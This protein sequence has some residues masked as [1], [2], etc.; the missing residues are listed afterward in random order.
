MHKKTRPY[1][2][3]VVVAGLLLVWVASGCAT[4]SGGMRK[5]E[6][7]LAAND[8]AGALKELED[9]KPA[10]RDQVLYR[11][12]RGIIQ[13]M[14]G[15][16]KA[17]SESFEST[18]A[19]S[20]KL[21]AVSVSEQAGAVTV[22]DSMRAYVGEPHERLLMQVYTMLNYMESG[23]F[24]GAR[25][26][27]LQTDTLQQRLFSGETEEPFS[28]YLTGIVYESLG[29]Y[30]DALIAYRKSYQSY[31]QGFKKQP[32]PIPF[33]LKED[34]L[35]FTDFRGMTDESKEFQEQFKINDWVK[36][37]ATRDKGE[38]ILVYNY[39]LAP[40]MMEH[41]TFIKVA[42]RGGN[43]RISLPYYPDRGNLSMPRARMVVGDQVRAIDVVADVD[44][45]A[46]RMLDEKLPGVLARTTARAIV[47]TKV[48]NEIQKQNGALG[49]L[50]NVAGMVSEVADT[51]SWS[52][53]PS[54]I[55]VT[56]M[57]LAPGTYD[58]HVQLVDAGGAQL[59]EKILTGVEIK[60]GKKKVQSVHWVTA[61][62][63]Y[64][65]RH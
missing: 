22:N 13:R 7:R 33:S 25:V 41:S 58:I 36:M 59:P 51:R 18:K 35:R 21:D 31:K 64:A 57:Y 55:G 37:D 14:K 8:Y 61:R 9:Q 6:S 60:K 38:L 43:I 15:D 48:S 16:L 53:L 1:R 46:R 5:V 56:R 17:S 11:Y 3:G 10:D 4:Y 27:A 54:F 32:L 47:K 19:L 42:E 34:L 20:E 49:L 26:E 40:L 23:D 65:R 28:R 30:D 29:E 52:T 24:D 50:A 12:N 39:G 44:A 63:V 45:I 62:P 2:A